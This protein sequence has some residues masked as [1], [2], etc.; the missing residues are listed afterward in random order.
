LS[1]NEENKLVYE[2]RFPRLPPWTAR[3]PAPAL[4]T[5]SKR[6]WELNI[7]IHFKQIDMSQTRFKWSYILITEK[8]LIIPLQEFVN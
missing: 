8:N 6:R 3:V 2:G 4:T 5:K 1:F 7:I